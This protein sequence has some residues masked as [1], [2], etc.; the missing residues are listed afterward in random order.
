MSQ[1]LEDEITFHDSMLSFND[2]LEFFEEVLG[3]L[4]D[5]IDEL[6]EETDDDETSSS[7]ESE[8]SCDVESE[9]EES[10]FITGNDTLENSSFIG[11]AESDEDI[12][13][14]E[15]GFNEMSEQDE[16][17]KTSSTKNGLNETKNTFFTLS[18]EAN[19]ANEADEADEADEKSAFIVMDE[20]A[21]DNAEDKSI[22]DIQRII[23]GMLSGF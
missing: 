2:G 18:D 9:P 17:L 1:K 21:E 5:R 13:M 20:N 19:E 10:P 4:R 22:D 6:S 3:G 16:K 11:G 14:D 23:G 8:C 7:E 15:F 12:K